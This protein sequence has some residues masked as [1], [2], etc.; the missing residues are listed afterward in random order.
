MKAQVYDAG[1][2]VLNSGDDFHDN[3]LEDGDSL[4]A[5]VLDKMQTWED[6]VNA[7]Y[8]SQWDEYYRIWRGYWAEEDKTRQSERSRIVTPATQQA[9]ESS[10]ADIEEATF[11]H[12]ELFDIADDP[13]DPENQDI[14]VLRRQ[15]DYD[16]RKQ[17]IRQSCAQ[18]LLNA[19]VYGTGAAEIVLEEVNDMAPAT[20]PT[21]GGE[22]TAIG[23]NITPRTVV[24]MRPIQMKNFR[25]DPVATS[26]EEAH[27]VGTDEF[28]SAHVVQQLQEEGVY[29]DVFVGTAPTDTDIE[30]NPEMDVNPQDQVRLM[31]YFGLVPRHLL[32]KANGLAEDEEYADIA[33]PEDVDTSDDSY[34]VEAIVVIANEGVL[35]KAEANPYMMQDRPIV[36]FQ[37]D[38]VPG[39]FWGRGVVEKAYN[40]Q[41]AL[42]AEIRARIDALALTV[43]PMLA[44]DATRI[45]RGHTPQVRPGKMLL[46][47]GKPSDVIMPFN[48]GSVS[49]ITFEQ[50]SQLQGMVQQATGAVDGQAGNMGSNNKTG[51]VSMMLGNI[52]KRQKRTLLNFQEC[53]WVP[54]VEKAAWRYMQFDPETYPVADYKF[55]ATSTLGVMARE[56]EVSQLV[57]LLQTMSPDSPMYPALVKSIVNNMNLNNRE[58]LEAIL[59]QASQPDPKQQQMQEQMHQMAMAKE[60]A[61]IKAVNAQAYE[62]QMRGE[63]Y[64]MSA[65]MQPVEMEIKKI[66]AV[67]KNL[68]PGAGEDTEFVRR[69]KI[70]ETKLKERDLNIKEAESRAKIE[71]MKADR[72]AGDKLSRVLGGA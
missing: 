33:D 37:W 58:E 9:V 50:A 61:T 62:S 52:V 59:D 55:Q 69:L 60:E 54:F 70:A 72:E 39:L 56:Y 5:Y 3:M 17:K 51:A 14:A 21:M 25:I 67:T 47:N 6:F 26:I 4:E 8:F 22:M 10:T 32:D 66:D 45:P 41:K 44:M 12:G 29:R 16:F 19:A 36:S 49:Q 1:A 15:L 65:E 2:E 63:N 34:W 48:F 40:S 46:T 27:G 68:Q 71:Q 23:V 42:D 35:L 20:Q 53:F 64:K 38:I 43:H 7:N 11:G 18:V 31:K 28:V 30:P 13:M 57:Q 24:K